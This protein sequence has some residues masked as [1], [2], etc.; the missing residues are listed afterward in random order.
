M[1]AFNKIQYVIYIH[2]TVCYLVKVCGG[3]GAFSL[4]LKCY[5]PEIVRPSPYTGGAPPLSCAALR[6]C[7]L[8]VQLCVRNLL[9]VGADLLHRLPSLL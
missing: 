2:V 8:Q 4:V 9:L 7:A 6:L 5:G 1:A 3:G